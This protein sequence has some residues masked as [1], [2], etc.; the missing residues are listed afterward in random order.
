MQLSLPF[1]RLPAINPTGMAKIQDMTTIIR[2]AGSEKFKTKHL[3][4]GGVYTRTVIVPTHTL[5]TGV[6]LK[7]P[8]TLIVVGK[9]SIYVGE[10]TILLRGY[11]VLPGSADRQC[12]FYTHSTVGMSMSLATTATSVEE[13]QKEFTDETHLLVPLENTD[14][15]EI[16]VTGE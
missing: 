3:V 5:F 14:E 16:V 12:A 10:K 11:N 7:V 13:I 4:H 9:I 15:H 8:T 6:L 1:E 2:K